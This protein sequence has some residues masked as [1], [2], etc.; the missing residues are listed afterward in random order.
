MPNNSRTKTDLQR[1]KGADMSNSKKFQYGIG[2]FMLSLMTIVLT[3]A[4]LQYISSSIWTAPQSFLMAYA[5][6][7]AVLVMAVLFSWF[8][9]LKTLNN[10]A[11]I[12]GI[13]YQIYVFVGIAIAGLLVCLFS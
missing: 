5:T 13:W 8:C 2:G 11:M 9:L 12:R 6:T 10:E 7:F 4:S 3:A 1:A